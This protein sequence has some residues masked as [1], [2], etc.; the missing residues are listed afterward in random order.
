MNKYLWKKGLQVALIIVSL[1]TLT[2]AAT[3]SYQELVDSYFQ[4]YFIS[5]PSS[6]TYYGIHD[7][8]SKL[9]D[10]SLAAHTKNR[11]SL[12]SYLH[13]FQAVNTKD[14]SATDR[15][16][17]ELVIN[18]IKS[19]LLEEE[20]LQ[21]WRKNPDA[22]SGGVTS[23]IFTLIK[24][25]FAPAE[26]RLR[27][28][29]D[30]EK[31][32]PQAL[33]SATS[34]LHNPPKIYT[35]TAIQQLPGIIG[36]FQNTVPAA[37]AGVKDEK[38]SQEFAHSN[39]QAIKALKD[40]QNFLQKDL[41]P[42]SQGNFAIGAKNYQLKLRY[43][44][45]VDI[46]LDR[47]LE[48]GYAQLHKDQQ[49][50]LETTKRIDATKSP[51]EVIAILEKDHPTA[52]GLIPSAQ[53]MLDGLR[54]FL[55]DKK[56]ITIPGGVQAKVV[57]TPAFLRATTFASMD[58]PGPFETQASEAYYNITLPDP[59]WSADKQEEYLQGYNYAL[60]SNVSV[61]EV[62]PG[63][64]LQF[65][66]LKN[67]PQL[68]KV[69]KIIDSGSNA[70]GW[71]HY[72]EQMI[73]DEGFGNNDAKLRLAQLIDALLRDC[74]YIVG[75]Q[76][77]TKQMSY[78]Q[79]IDFFVKEGYQQRVVGETEA[80]RGTSDPTYLIYTLGK[81]QILKLRQDYQQ[82]MGD[83]FTLQDFHDRFIN[84]GSPPLKIVQRELLGQETP[85]LQ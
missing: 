48:I 46:P 29:I 13:K 30:R 39:E 50:L 31:Q 36:F 17:L 70:E 75:L 85:L 2:K 76:M 55:L 5:H 65:L 34:I 6:A 27:A 59:N 54:Q 11:K 42:H 78:D 18:R 84:A 16:D 49:A 77:H 20:Q 15:N 66:S 60:I 51:L 56:I 3:P 80:R 61:H 40:Y 67:N 82:K 47:L 8:D 81:L 53:Q 45:M 10:V 52:A 43:E 83:K 72:T 12:Q 1:V 4:D 73:L 35:E 14:L 37:F 9:E 69:R 38:L 23:S 44:E 41:L 22:Y 57:E 28:V 32:I 64:Y 19:E 63:H 79:A 58:T 62:W 26:V 21:M 71:A 74:R 68:S 25:N 24:R 7:Y 33:K